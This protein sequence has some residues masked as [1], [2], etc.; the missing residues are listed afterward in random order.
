MNRKKF[1]VEGNSQKEKEEFI[2]NYFTSVKKEKIH[3]PKSKVEIQSTVVPER[4][5]FDETFK[6]IYFLLKQ[7]I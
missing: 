3:K 2:N 5:S 1:I 4:L 7:A 6:R